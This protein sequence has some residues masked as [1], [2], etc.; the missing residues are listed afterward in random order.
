MTPELLAEM[1]NAIGYKPPVTTGGSSDDDLFAEMDSVLGVSAPKETSLS[2]TEKVGIAMDSLK[3]GKALA[4]N[5][6]QQLT[7]ELPV[8]GNIVESAKRGINTTVKG[9]KDLFSSITNND[10]NSSQSL[11]QNI[12]QGL[13]GGLGIVA[14]LAD[15]AFSPITGAVQSIPGVEKAFQALDENVAQPIADK[16]SDSKRLQDFVME[17]PNTE[18][19]VQNAMTVTGLFQGG[20]KIKPIRGAIT[21]AVETTGKVSNTVLRKAQELTSASEKSIESKIMSRYEKAIKPTISG[22]GT[23]TQITQYNDNVLSG[24]DS[25]KENQ[26]LLKFTDEAGDVI[27]GKLPE[28]LNQFVDAVDQTK[29]SIYKKYSDISKASGEEG[30]LVKFDSAISELDS[31][32]NNE[33]LAIT[34]P[35][36]VTYAQNYKNRLSKSAALRPELTE[37]I[38][39]NINNDLKTFYRNPQSGEVSKMAVN[40][41][42]VNKLRQSLEETISGATGKEYSALKRQYGSLVALEKDIVKAS[43]RDARK[44]VKGLI[45]FSDILSGGQITSGLLSGN[46][47]LVGSGVSQKAIA[48]FYKHLNNPNRGVKALFGDVEA[49][50]KKRARSSQINPNLSTKYIKAD[51]KAVSKNAEAWID[52]NKDNLKDKALLKDLSETS[53]KTYKEVREYLNAQN[54]LNRDKTLIER[55]KET[56]NKQGGFA[57]NPFVRKSKDTLGDSLKKD[58]G[59]S[60]EFFPDAIK[61]K[62][63]HPAQIETINKFID[64]HHLKEVFSEADTNKLYPILE[65]EGISPDL[66]QA[67]IVKKLESILDGTTPSKGT[68]VDPDSVVPMQSLIDDRLKPLVDNDGMVTV[69]RAAKTHPKDVYTKDTFFAT[70]KEN[71]EYYGSSWYKGNPSDLEVKEIKVPA[72]LLK[73]GGSSDTWQLVE[74]IPVS[75]VKKPNIDVPDQALIQEA[76]KYKSVEEF[77]KKKLSDKEYITVYHRTNMPLNE[78]GKNP[79]YSKENK[80]EFFVSNRPDEQIV[81]YGDNVVKLRVKKSDLEINDEFPSGEEHYTIPTTVADEAIKTKSQLEEIYKKANQTSTPKKTS[82]IGSEPKSINTFVK[83]KYGENVDIWTWQKDGNIELSKIIIDKKK[84]GQGIGTEV[85]KDIL[86]HADKTAQTVTLTP[87]GEFGG[88]VARLK[89][90]YG[91]LGFVKNKDLGIKGT[92]IYKSKK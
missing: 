81:G 69:Y 52:K 2:D 17:N 79:I 43:L 44:N 5:A 8:V 80:G 28:N 70:K 30:M 22:K 83:D 87:G 6:A 25:I 72:N 86:K 91:N 73:R 90:F 32:I 63:I 40:A 41:L 13:R 61:V 55:I 9:A 21:D 45:D 27:E 58:M 50:A 62:N 12:Q 76:K 11:N 71:A 23:K 3:K 24:A 36:T 35:D 49:L 18:E 38:I 29:S 84:R 48:S 74:D 10:V 66:P 34:H 31:V 53:P 19:V 78:F 14:G 15:T 60:D 68:Y 65:R 64:S 77:V 16:I 75:G 92:M 57:K 88:S 46:L 7:P 59:K 56:P 89:K 26:A 54:I 37:E 20:A 33:S 1:D 39:K 67:T 47:A 85:M 4:R 42:V 82:N 51:G